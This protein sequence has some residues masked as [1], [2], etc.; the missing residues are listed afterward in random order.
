LLREAGAK[1]SW[2]SAPWK[3]E[4]FSRKGAKRAKAQSILCD[5]F[6]PLRENSVIFM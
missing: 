6:A 5:I 4:E 1:V 3:I 2:E